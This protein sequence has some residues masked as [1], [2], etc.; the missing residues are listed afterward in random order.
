MI[1]TGATP[2]RVLAGLLVIIAFTYKPISLRENILSGLYFL[3]SSLWS[4]RSSFCV[5]RPLLFLANSSRIGFACILFFPTKSL[6]MFLFHLISMASQRDVFALTGLQER[7]GFWRRFSAY[8]L[9]SLLLFIILRPIDRKVEHL[10]PQDISSIANIAPSLLGPAFVFVLSVIVVTFA[11]WVV[12]EFYFGQTVGK[13]LL[14]IKVRSTVGRKVSFSQILIRNLAKIFSFILFIDT[15][16]LL[17]KGERL[18]FSDV[19]A[20]TEVVLS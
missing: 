7:A 20:K 9:D 15:I 10:V 11:Y 3:T 8:V 12:F 19:V 4:A 6:N 1:A 18:R 17:V 2:E 16:Y 14:G 13:M 5:V